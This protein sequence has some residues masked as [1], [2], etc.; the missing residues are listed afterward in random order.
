MLAVHKTATT[1]IFSHKY[2]FSPLPACS[3]FSHS[4]S[5][6][7]GSARLHWSNC[8]KLPFSRVCGITPSILTLHHE[9]RVSHQGG[10]N[11]AFLQSKELISWTPQTS[12]Q[13]RLDSWLSFTIWESPGQR[14]SSISLSVTSMEWWHVITEH[15]T[16]HRPGKAS[17][18]QPPTVDFTAFLTKAPRE[19]SKRPM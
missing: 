6:R 5:S 7:R 2:S 13:A 4:V 17:C 18:T 3:L 10:P 8:A 11:K 9:N 1:R 14:D 12:E 15:R 16:C 19:A